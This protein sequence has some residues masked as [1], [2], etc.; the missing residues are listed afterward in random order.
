M[1]KEKVIVK[2]PDMASFTT[3]ISQHPILCSISSFLSTL[4]LFNL[5]LTDSIHYLHILSSR[6]TFDA[7]CRHCL[8]DG[9]GLTKR[10]E[11]IGLY[12]LEDRFYKRGSSRKIWQDEPIEVRL[13]GTKCDETGALPCR[14]CGIRICEVSLLG[15]FSMRQNCF[16]KQ[17]FPS[18]S[19]KV[20]IR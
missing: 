1:E 2:L 16:G 9:S 14:K 7:L 8:C 10:Q 4:D 6:A 18:C 11:F 17:R 3:L 13:Y 15:N 5:A 12:S 20:N 19:S